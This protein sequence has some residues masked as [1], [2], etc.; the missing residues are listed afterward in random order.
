M[1]PPR[2]LSA[3]PII[4]WL[5]RIMPVALVAILFIVFFVG[6]QPAW[7]IE[8]VVAALF[9]LGV[10][11]LVA[12]FQLSALSSEVM[13]HGDHL[14]I[15]AAGR[16]VEVPLAAISDVQYKP[17]MLGNLVTLYFHQAGPFGTAIS[18]VP[19]GGLRRSTQVDVDFLR[20]RVLQAR[21]SG[22]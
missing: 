10:L 15:T 9:L 21:M 3:G 20:R 16:R 18:Y 7:T 22:T 1:N 14:V 11:G 19:A 17:V 4:V 6:P 8:R 2:R 12:W 5:G 13:D